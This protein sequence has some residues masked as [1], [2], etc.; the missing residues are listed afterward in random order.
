MP[1]VRSG[2]ITYDSQYGHVCT[3]TEATENDALG[4]PLYHSYLP[5]VTVDRSTRPTE[6]GSYYYVCSRCG[7]GGW[8]GC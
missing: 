4:E 1:R 8:S 5:S 3:C 6:S 7:A 2:E